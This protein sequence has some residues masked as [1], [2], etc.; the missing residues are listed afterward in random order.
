MVPGARLP[1][2]VISHRHRFVFVHHPRTAG[3]SIDT[4]F[5]CSRP[6]F[7]PEQPDEPSR[8]LPLAWYRD[9]FPDLFP[10]YFKFCFVRNPWDR[11]VSMWTNS[12]ERV[13][14]ELRNAEASLATGIADGKQQRKLER[15]VERRRGHPA[16]RPFDEWLRAVPYGPQLIDD[17]GVFD[18]VG[19]FEELP[20]AWAEVCSRLGIVLPLPH[21]NRTQHRHYRDYYDAETRELVAERCSADLEFLGYRF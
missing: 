14:T 12:R 21:T 5:G 18:F 9:R 1:G 6:F 15:L 13:M 3:T 4:V 17:D 11:L 2:G 7:N 8:H 16:L 10:V 19:R 20:E